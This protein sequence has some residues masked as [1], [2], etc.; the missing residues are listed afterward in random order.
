M[1]SLVLPLL[2][3]A[4]VASAATTEQRTWGAV[5]VSSFLLVCLLV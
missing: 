3:F 5:V 1:A 2:V 4:G